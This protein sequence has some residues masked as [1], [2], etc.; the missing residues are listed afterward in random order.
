M[1]EL[2]KRLSSVSAYRAKQTGIW[3]QIKDR[4]DGALILSDLD[5][6]VIWLDL[7]ELEIPPPWIEE[8]YELMDRRREEIR[9]EDIGQIV[10]DKYDFT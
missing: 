6:L 9:A 10:R 7:H 5:E 1:G 8:I 4:I 3:D 2:L